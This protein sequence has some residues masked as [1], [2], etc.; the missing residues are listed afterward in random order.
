MI[1]YPE[2]LSDEYPHPGPHYTGLTS[3]VSDSQFKH[4]GWVR[5]V[6][7]YWVEGQE[8][9]KQELDAYVADKRREMAIV[10]DWVEKAASQINAEHERWISVQLGFERTIA[11]IR[12]HCPFK[13]D[14][15]Y[16]EATPSPLLQCVDCRNTES[17]AGAMARAFN[18]G[19]CVH[20]GGWFKVVRA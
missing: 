12:E 6:V 7:K 16:V 1:N 13:P 11:I 18:H 5:G 14:V 20:C 10:E 2:P 9:T 17:P 15:A 3:F 4:D 8:V 19:R